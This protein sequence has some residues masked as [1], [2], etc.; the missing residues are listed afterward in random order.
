MNSKITEQHQNK[1]A[2]IY[3]ASRLWPKY[4]TIKRARNASMHCARKALELAGPEELW[5]RWC[6]RRS[7]CVQPPW[8]SSVQAQFQRLLAPVHTGVPSPLDGAVLGP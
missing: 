6:T 2:Y 7:R 8:T 1:P 5:R 4:G 3:V